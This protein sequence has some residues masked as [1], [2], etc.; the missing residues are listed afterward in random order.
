M[1]FRAWGG[2]RLS[3][4]DVYDIPVPVEDIVQPDVLTLALVRETCMVDNLPQ[5][6]HDVPVDAVMTPSAAI[7]INRAKCP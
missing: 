5:E 2:E 6:P 1:Q 4:T 3:K 7:K